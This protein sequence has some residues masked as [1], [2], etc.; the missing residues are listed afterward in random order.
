MTK[1]RLYLFDTTRRRPSARRDVRPEDRQM[2]DS[3]AAAG[4]ER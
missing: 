4:V 1:E 3:V 2:Q